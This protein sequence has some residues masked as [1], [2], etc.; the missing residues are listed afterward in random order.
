MLFK[1]PNLYILHINFY[2]VGFTDVMFV[3]EYYKK[4]AP[5]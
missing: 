1:V 2:N 3:Q 5:E 4:N